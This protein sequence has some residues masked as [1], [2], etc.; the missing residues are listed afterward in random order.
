M[1]T[2]AATSSPHNLGFHI[3]DE[4]TGT[5][6]LVDTGA[7]CS[8]YP[9]APHE[10]HIVDTDPLLLTAANGTAISSHGTKDI[11]LQFNSRKYTWSFRLAQVSQPLLGSDFLAQHNLLVD[12]ARR[13]LISADTFNYVQL[14]T[15]T[16]PVHQLNVCSTPNDKYSGI[17]TE[18]ADVF[19][20]ELRQ[21]HTAKPKHGIFHHI[22]TTGPP[23]H[24]RFRRLN[25]QKLA[26]AKSAFNEME[27]MGICAKASSP[28]A[29]PLHMV[30]AFWGYH[31]H[32]LYNN[33]LSPNYSYCILHN[34]LH[35]STPVISFCYLIITQ[36][37]NY[38]INTVA[39]DAFVISGS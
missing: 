1:T 38:C 4:I 29:S 28:W 26:A 15:N 30:V 17:I 16:D 8:V 11:Q 27:S 35:C 2:A 7:F 20:P 32:L 25:P 31:I 21:Q 33:L 6:F 10:R 36:L 19:K 9:A 37:Y 14:Q 13:R 12:V 24:S 5:L 18:Y 34:H 22:P 23:V 39:S 3:K